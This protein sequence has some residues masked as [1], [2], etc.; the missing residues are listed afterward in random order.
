M[1]LN[2]LVVYDGFLFAIKGKRS[3]PRKQK[4]VGGG[5]R[6]NGAQR[7]DL[8]NRNPELPQ[9]GG[10]YTILLCDRYF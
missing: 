4:T 1:S 6:G 8:A 3:F 9:G 7:N 5:L 2:V 10:A